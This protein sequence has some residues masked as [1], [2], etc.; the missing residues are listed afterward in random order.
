MCILS[1]CVSVHHMLALTILKAAEYLCALSLSRHT[2]QWP[3]V[4]GFARAEALVVRVRQKHD[5]LL[6]LI[7]FMCRFCCMYVCAPCIH[8]VPL[9]ARRGHQIDTQNWSYRQM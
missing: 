2:L 4:T 7:H 3:L 8:M 9:E 5:M 6:F 1:T